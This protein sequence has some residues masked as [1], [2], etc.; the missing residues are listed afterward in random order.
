MYNIYYKYKH[1]LFLIVKIA[2]VTAAI[3]VIYQKL[4]SSSLLTVNK[5]FTQFEILFSNNFWLLILVLLLT[6][7][8]WIAEI[9]KWK[10]L[11][12]TLK[13]ITFFEA[14]EQSLAS[15]TASIITPNR[16]GEYGVKALYFESEKQ[17]KIVLLNLIG[18]LS[19]LLVTV[20]FGV[21]GLFFLFTNFDILV[22]KL[23][24]FKILVIGFFFLI[25]FLF[26]KQLKIYKIG[27]YFK[28]FPLKI[29]LKVGYLAV[30]RYLF[31]TH[32]FY[33]LLILFGVEANYLTIMYLL[34]CMYLLASIIPSLAIFDWAIKGSLAIYLF[35]LI[36]FNELTLVTVTTLMWLLNFAIPSLIGSIFVITFK[37]P[38][39]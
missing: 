14:Y 21:I 17:K 25:V 18:N 39:K 15:L 19:Q 12:S 6:D 32:Q 26:R 4:N 20:L 29:Y 13:K 2:I 36:G 11:V 24:M 23:N 8:N 22:P 34:F 7:A 30:L 5:L 27:Q 28:K 38:T 1:L 31:F 35:G 33:L 10:T 16:I 37:L 3:Y 9:L